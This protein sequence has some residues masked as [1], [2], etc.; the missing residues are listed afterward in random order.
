MR[1]RDRYRIQATEINFFKNSKSLFD[2]RAS[3]QMIQEQ[4]PF[5]VQY[6]IDTHITGRFIWKEWGHIK[7]Q[8]RLQDASLD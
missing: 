7:Y 3:Q 5:S 6:T 2:K 4:Q 1:K 8:N